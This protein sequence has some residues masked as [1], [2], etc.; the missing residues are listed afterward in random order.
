[1]GDA[2]LQILA[3]LGQPPDRRR[4]VMRQRILARAVL[5][6]PG[7]RGGQFLD[8][9]LQPMAAVAGARQGMA[10]LA[11]RIARG[12]RGG[13]GP[14]GAVSVTRRSAASASILAAPAASAASRQRAKIIRASATRICSEIKR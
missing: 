10:R 4:R 14:R 1:M 6:D 3:L 12:E 2:R 7:A 5:I 11:Q 8:P 9:P 13:A